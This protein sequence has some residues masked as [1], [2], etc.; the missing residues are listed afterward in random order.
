MQIS[1]VTHYVY[2]FQHLFDLFVC[3]YKRAHFYSITAQSFGSLCA[4]QLILATHVYCLSDLYIISS[5]NIKHTLLNSVTCILYKANQLNHEINLFIFS[6]RIILVR[7]VAN[8]DSL[9]HL[10]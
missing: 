7:V 5:L 10:E 6:N 4:S 9:Q 1:S 2:H 3:L 8:S